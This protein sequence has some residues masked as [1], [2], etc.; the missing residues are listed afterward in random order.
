MIVL[1]PPAASAGK[2][3]TTFNP[4]FIACSTSLGLAHPGK[5]GI[6]FSI[7]YSTTSGLSPGLTINSAPALTASS[8]CEVVSTVPAPT[9]ISGYASF[10]FLIASAACSVR[11]VTSAHGNPPSHNAFARGFASCASSNFT[12]GTIPIFLIL[13]NNISCSIMCLL[14]KMVDRIVNF[15]TI[16]KTYRFF[17]YFSL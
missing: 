7:Q 14:R 5:I 3:F 9:S 6:F 10:I 2:N 1:I 15:L 12:T 13:S 17:C 8:T 16:C 11:N 4:Y